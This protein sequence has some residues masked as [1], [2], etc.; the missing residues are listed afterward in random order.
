MLTQGT[1]VMMSDEERYAGYFE[2]ETLDDALDDNARAELDELLRLFAKSSTWEQPPP[3]LADDV[4]AGI[5]AAAVDANV[6]P[7]IA[8]VPQAVPAPQAAPAIPRRNWF[9]PALAVAAAVVLVI[10][11]GAV[12]VTRGEREQET[13]ALAATDVIPG[14]SGEASLEETGSGLSISL[15]VQGL[16]PAEPGTFYQ[17]WMRGDAGSVPIGTFHA[18]QSGDSIEL[19]SGVDVAEYP[20]M[21]VTLQQEGAGPE[22]S[23]VVVLRGDLPQP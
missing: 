14:A 2:G 1:V 21:T 6:D 5:R 7:T 22:S 19:W 23:G 3:D 11:L 8:P 12:L 9:R 18:R 13:F 17:A 4:V 16:P 10:A 20:T 15:S